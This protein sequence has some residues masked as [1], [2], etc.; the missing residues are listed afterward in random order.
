MADFDNIASCIRQEFDTQWPTL[1]PTIDH[2]FIGQTIPIKELENST[3]V[4]VAINFGES[5]QVAMGGGTSG[6]RVRTVGVVAVNIF[7][8]NGGGDGQLFRLADSVASIW[9][10]S[11]IQGIVYRAASAQ[12]IQRDGP[13][14]ILPV[15][16]PFFADEY[17][18]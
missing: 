18:T 3:W 15:F 5:Q 16:T 1:Q 9:Q 4:R 17:V 7:A 6:R 8:P 11:T 2:Y 14:V 13:W 12:P 10:V